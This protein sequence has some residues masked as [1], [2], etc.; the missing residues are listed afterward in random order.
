MN[1]LEFHTSKRKLESGNIKAKFIRKVVHQVY[2][3]S[4]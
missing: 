3:K 1:D 2:Y 4:N